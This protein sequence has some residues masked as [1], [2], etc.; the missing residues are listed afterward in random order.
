MRVIAGKAK[1]FK[2][3]MVP[4]DKTRPVMDIVKE[5]AFNIIA[6]YIFHSSFLDLYAG[7]G[8]VGIEALSRGA[9]MARFVDVNPKATQT[10]HANLE[11]TGLEEGAEV[12]QKDVFSMLKMP[13][14]REFDFVYIAPPQYKKLWARTLETL[15]ANMG[16]LAEDAWVIVQIDPVE[17]ETVHLE[18][19]E[20]FDR[21]VYGST[22]LLFFYP[23]AEEEGPAAEHE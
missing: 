22:E 7:T 10:I 15:D 16:W 5:S 13:P 4:G 17:E 12:W 9:S 8:S 19:L 2:L 23:E 6:P 21:R 18:N 11:H 3:Y 1:G 14:D 20:L